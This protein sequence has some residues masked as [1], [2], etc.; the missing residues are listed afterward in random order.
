M[1]DSNGLQVSP[2]AAFFRLNQTDIALVPVSLIPHHV[3]F[4]RLAPQ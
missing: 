4:G 3:A 2:G 1:A